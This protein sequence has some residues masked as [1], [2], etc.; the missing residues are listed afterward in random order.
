VQRGKYVM[1]VLLGT[2][3]P[4]APPVVP[5]LPENAELRTGHVAKPLSVRQRMEEHRKNP[6]CAGCHKMMD[7]IGFSL[8]NFDVLGVWRTND[9]GYRIDSAGTMFDGAKLDGP[10]SLR[11]A[12]L[13]HSDLFLQTF[14]ENLLAYG[15]GR[16][17]EPSDMPVVRSVAKEAARNNNRFSALVM[18]IVKSTPFQMR[19]AE[20][21]IPAATDDIVMNRAEKAAAA[22]QQ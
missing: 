11:Q 17:V 3:P 12:I 14:A 1:E 13:G 2:P 18:A 16:V 9:S 22:G 19:R 6:A 5:A 21:K 8:E 4:P 15:L 10:A 7:P 20:E